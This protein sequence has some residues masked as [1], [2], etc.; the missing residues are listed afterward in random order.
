MAAEPAMPMTEI[1]NLITTGPIAVRGQSRRSELALRLGL[2]PD[3]RLVLVSMGGISFRLPMEQ[4]PSTPGIRYIVQQNWQVVRDDSVALE[5]LGISFPD[6][7][8]S[9]DLLLTKP[10]YGNFSEAA[11]NG[12]PVLYAPRND[13]PESQWL[14]RWL[15]QH[16][17]CAA[18][19]HESLERGELT[20]HIEALLSRG[21]PVPVEPSGIAQAVA[22]IEAL[23]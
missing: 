16:G 2:Q 1:G 10:G 5:S 9:C 23:L 4:W 19:S 21:R 15:E 20:A 13:W 12:T 14:I 8:A 3:E 17:H 11:I 7:F 22:A 18:V 6:L